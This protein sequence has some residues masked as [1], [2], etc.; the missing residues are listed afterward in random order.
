MHQRHYVPLIALLAS[1]LLLPGALC[2]GPARELLKAGPVKQLAHARARLEKTVTE[3]FSK[4]AAAG[5]HAAAGVDRA[6]AATARQ[7]ALM[8]A[9]ADAAAGRAAKSRQRLCALR[10]ARRRW[11]PRLTARPRRPSP[12]GRPP[13]RARSRG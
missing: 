13:R 3:G 12:C 2:D 10:R 1:A 6:V 9:R 8:D 5:A 7:A 11:C 4:T